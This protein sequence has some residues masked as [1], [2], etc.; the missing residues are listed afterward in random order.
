MVIAI[1][2]FVW[3]TP[4]AWIGD[5]HAS[6][7]RADRLAGGLAARLTAAPKHAPRDHAN[8]GEPTAGR[9]DT[10]HRPR[11]GLPARQPA[12]RL[13]AAPLPAPPLV[14][15]PD[16]VG[17]PADASPGCS[18]PSGSMLG[19]VIVVKILKQH[20]TD[21]FGET[22]MLLYY[23]YLGP[24]T[25]RIGRGFYRDGVWL[26]SGF[27]PYEA[28]G[29]LTWREEPQP[30][31]VVLPRM[32]RL[33]KLLTVPPQHYA[34]ARRLLARQDHRPRHPLHRQ[35]PRPRRPRRARRRLGPPRAARP[36]R[37]DCTGLPRA[38]PAAAAWPSCGRVPPPIPRSRRPV[39]PPRGWRSPL[40]TRLAPRPPGRSLAPARSALVAAV[41][42]A[43][44]CRRCSPGVM[45]R[46]GRTPAAADDGRGRARA[47]AVRRRG[48]AGPPDRPRHLLRR[49]LAHPRAPGR[50]RHRPGRSRRRQLPLERRRGSGPAR[51]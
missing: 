47:P 25:M 3:L 41:A 40:S 11:C 30:T 9:R 6:G 36:P 45:P 15:A 20:R 7:P 31:L 21:I 34:E 23:V 19:V 17:P 8:G 48:A 37:P 26:D 50:H 35:G 38:G 29:G 16:L 51:A 39:R 27:M 44:A 1:L 32:K 24:L 4:P 5:P 14:G 10:P 28:I 2:A 49:R 12:A 46:P 43:P 42:A 13:P 22:M 18:S 33:A